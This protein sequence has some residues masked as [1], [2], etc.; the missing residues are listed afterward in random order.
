MHDEAMAGAHHDA[1]RD[2]E[3]LRL[4]LGLLLTAP[5]G[6]D[7]DYTFAGEGD[8]D[9]T[10]VNIV[11]ASFGGSTYKLFIGRFQQS[12]GRSRLHRQVA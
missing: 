1:M 7:V 3:L 12:S 9:G 11:N 8:L 5:D 6:M 4:T 10:P 2:N